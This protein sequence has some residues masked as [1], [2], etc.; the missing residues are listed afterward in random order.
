[1]DEVFNIPDGP[2]IIG[3]INDMNPR[4]GLQVY[5][6]GEPVV[7]IYGFE[8]IEKYINGKDWK[9]IK[10]EQREPEEEDLY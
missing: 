6:N 2:T 1:M 3:D 4:V 8:Q 7:L 10:R 5:E 9:K